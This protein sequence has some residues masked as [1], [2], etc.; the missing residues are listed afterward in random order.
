MLLS[1]ATSLIDDATVDMESVIMMKQHTARNM[2]R[3]VVEEFGATAL[4]LRESSV[5]SVLIASCLDED[6]KDTNEFEA[7]RG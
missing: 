7:R 3:A 2:R 5:V 4:K 6:T 1:T